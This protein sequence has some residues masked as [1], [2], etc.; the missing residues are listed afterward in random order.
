MNPHY[1]VTSLSVLRKCLLYFI[2]LFICPQQKGLFKL[3]SF[4]YWKRMSLLSFFLT[5]TV[6][7]SRYEYSHFT[8]EKI[9]VRN[10]AQVKCSPIEGLES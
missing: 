7:V 2:Q 9:S 5:M 10:F 1:V 3:L 6:S 4:H 8:D